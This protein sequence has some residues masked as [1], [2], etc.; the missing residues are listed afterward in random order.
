MNEQLKWRYCAIGN[1]IKT[2][3]DENKT[4]RYG[5]KAFPGGKKR[6]IF[7]ESVGATAKIKL[8]FLDLIDSGDMR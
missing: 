4:I 6:F 5:S 8:R 7:A 2:H 3:L 1:I